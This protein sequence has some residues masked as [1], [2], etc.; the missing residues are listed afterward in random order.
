MSTSTLASGQRTL[1]ALIVAA[2]APAPPSARSSR[3]THVTTAWARPIRLTASATRSGSEASRANGLRV[4]IRQNAQAR[5]QRSPLTMKVAVPSAQHSKMLG[6]PASSQT[7]TRSRSPMTDRVDSNPRSRRTGMRSQS[8]FLVPMASP[9]S[10]TTPAARRRRSSIEPDGIIRAGSPAIGRTEAVS[11]S[12]PGASASAIAEARTP[13][14]SARDAVEPSACSD[15]TGRPVMP[16]GTMVEN[17][18]RSMFTFRETP[19]SVRRIPSTISVRIPMAET[20]AGVMV[21]MPTQTPG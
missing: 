2:I 12:R 11:T 4:S 20:L 7:V 21:S 9:A 18:A 15:V 14:T 10:G 8:G 13:P 3:A 17:S 19:W 1:I 5:V 16:Q 6:H